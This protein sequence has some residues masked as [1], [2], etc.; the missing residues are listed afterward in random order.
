MEK[1]YISI[2]DSPELIED[3]EEEEDDDVC[4][5]LFAYDNC[6]LLP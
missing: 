5:L 3:E 2:L 6:F 1:K 4:L